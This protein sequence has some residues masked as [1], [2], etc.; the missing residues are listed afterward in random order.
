MCLNV[1]SNC[2]EMMEDLWNL[3]NTCTSIRAMHMT[4]TYKM[5]LDYALNGLFYQ[6]SITMK[7]IQWPIF[8]LFPHKQRVMALQLNVK[9]KVTVLKAATGVMSYS[10]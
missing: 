9:F 8:E 4:T 10:Q 6:Y 1:A 2:R 7:T 3:L 5:I